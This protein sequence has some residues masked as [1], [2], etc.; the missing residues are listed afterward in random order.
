[1]YRVQQLTEYFSM[2]RP[3]LSVLMHRFFDQSSM[4]DVLLRIKNLKPAAGTSSGIYSIYPT[5]ISKL[6]LMK[7]SLQYTVQ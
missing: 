7:M 6:L 3:K 5:V 1:M 2:R 4:Q